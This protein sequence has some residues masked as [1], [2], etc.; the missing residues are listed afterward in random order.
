[1]IVEKINDYL[2]KKA[3][4]L[5]EA[6]R[7]E[8]EKL[9]GVAFKRQFMASEEKDSKGKIWF[10]SVGRCARQVAYQFHGFEKKGKEIDGR[11]R[12]I[13]WT[14]DLTELTL[15]T[16]AKLAG[17]N[18]IAYG[19]NQVRVEL[20]L[21]GGSISGRPD[22]LIVW[23]K[24]ILLLEVKSMSSYGYA[25]FERG[26]IDEAYLVQAN[27]GMESLG[28]RRCVFIAYDKDSGVMSELVIEKS[29]EI[30]NK[31]RQNVL[32]VL[33]STPEKLPPE[34]A[35]YGPDK[36]GLYTWN[37]LYCSYWK[38]C[39]PN[40]EKVLVKNAY[41][42]K[43]KQNGLR[44]TDEGSSSGHSEMGSGVREVPT[45]CGEPGRSKKN[46]SL[47]GNAEVLGSAAVE[48]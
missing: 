10:S 1:M 36:N 48:G 6:I 34:P 4:T 41:K 15:V 5:D 32:Q 11:A 13:F 16:L 9:A 42:L 19:L 21:N 43:E 26:E 18:I 14:G 40:A 2:S 37:C 31:A 22:G 12:M 7:Y 8:V 33:H 25:K 46:S 35:E 39:R 38:H 30:L 3:L 27:I 44:A 17:V 45:A 47:R 23:E 20:P 29:D 28:L 24:E